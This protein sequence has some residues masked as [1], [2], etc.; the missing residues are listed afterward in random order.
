MDVYE[1]CPVLEG[2]N[3]FLRLVEA[4][5]AEDLLEVYSDPD[6]A[7]LFNGDNCHGDD[8]RYATIA[9]MREAV[10][11]WDYSYRNRFFV[12][13]TVVH[14]PSGRAVGT[15]ELFR[16]DALS[17]DGEP[18]DFYHG[19]GL[20]RLDLRSDFERRDAIA[21]LLGVVGRSAYG[22]FQCEILATKV[23]PSATERARAMR[24]AGFR[25]SAAPLV[26]DDGTEYGNYWVR[27][28]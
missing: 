22:L 5:D 27:R 17:A 21:E 6:A 24:E 16:R 25:P 14:R 12:R 11:F 4:G 8:F 15:A 23:P 13:W 10:A 20:L 7:P 26:G 19:S 2:D 3:F 18:R 1:T 28:R 9:R